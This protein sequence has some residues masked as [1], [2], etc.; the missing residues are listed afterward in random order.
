MDTHS[1]TQRRAN[2]LHAEAARVRPADPELA[3]RLEEGA[4]RLALRAIVRADDR[5]RW[6]PGPG[7]AEPSPTVAHGADSAAS[8][9]S[10]EHG[11]ASE[12]E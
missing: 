9:G 12:A 2:A 4:R 11:P 1:E 5:A 7:G 3:E 8:A 6:R 10:V